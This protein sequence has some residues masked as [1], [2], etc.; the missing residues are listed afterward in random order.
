MA[1]GRGGGGEGGRGGGGRGGGGEGGRGGG[2]TVC[3]SN[4]NPS[5][6]SPTGP[7]RNLPVCTHRG[8]IIHDTIECPSRSWFHRRDRMYLTRVRETNASYQERGIQ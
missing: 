5:S 2:Q 4:H 3:L 7:L 6:L 1:L 8:S